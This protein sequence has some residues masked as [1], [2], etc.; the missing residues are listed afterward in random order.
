MSFD[1]AKKLTSAGA[2]SLGDGIKSGFMGMEQ[3]VADY[4]NGFNTATA[5]KVVFWL[6]MVF[7]LLL[8]IQ[9]AISVNLGLAENFNDKQDPHYWEFAVSGTMLGLSCG[10]VVVLG[11]F[12]IMYLDA[13]KRGLLK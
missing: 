5:G 7:S 12:G 11:A 1:R 8:L 10:G 2:R 6:A 13:K 3:K 4:A 9:S